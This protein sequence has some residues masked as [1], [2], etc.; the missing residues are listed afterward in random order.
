MLSVHR[1]RQSMKACE[2]TIAANVLKVS[3]LVSS[4]VTDR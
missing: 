4:D 2:T 1:G 3:D